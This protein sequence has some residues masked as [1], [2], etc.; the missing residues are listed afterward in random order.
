MWER[1]KLCAIRRKR[2]S[3]S[4]RSCRNETER[5]R[6][7]KRERR[8]KGVR[9]Q[10]EGRRGSTEPTRLSGY[11]VCRQATLLHIGSI[12]LP[13]SLHPSLSL[14]LS[15]IDATQLVSPHLCLFLAFSLF[16]SRSPR[17]TRSFSLSV[18]AASG[19]L[20]P[21]CSRSFVQYSMRERGREGWQ[22]PGGEKRRRRRALSRAQTQR[23]HGTR[24]HRWLVGYGWFVRTI[25]TS[26]AKGEPRE[27]SGKIP[28]SPSR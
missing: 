4:G 20:V 16:F 1:E 24:F 2:K 11:A 8:E 5:E 21:L 23:T 13:F 15:L 19:L 28:G 3:R 26:P 17:G 6:E 12:L 7:R 14:P 22:R 18:A 10:W 9:W 25:E 27:S